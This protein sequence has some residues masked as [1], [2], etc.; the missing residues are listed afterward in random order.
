MSV[1]TSSLR[2]AI[3]T[4]AEDVAR[5]TAERALD[6]VRPN[7][8]IGSSSGD[9]A[10]G[11][12]RASERNST[13]GTTIDIGYDAEHAVFTDE[14]TVA[15]PIYGNPYLSWEGDGMRVVV[16]ADRTP[17]Q[18]PGTPRQG[19]WSDVIG[20]E[21]DSYAGLQGIAQQVAAEVQVT[22]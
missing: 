11:E 7:V 18:H 16:I 5:E 2:A 20:T 17:V 4:W 14:G 22:A 15:H 6:L 1:D 10:P 19:W 8:P 13:S 12:L 21:G 3:Q 9:R